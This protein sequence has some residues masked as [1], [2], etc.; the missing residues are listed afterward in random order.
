MPRVSLD[1]ETANAIIDYDYNDTISV[2]IDLFD[3]AGKSRRYEDIP[4]YTQFGWILKKTLIRP[5]EVLDLK[6]AILSND[7]YY[8][9]K[10]KESTETEKSNTGYYTNNSFEG[11]TIYYDMDTYY[12][13]IMCQNSA[14][15]GKGK[16]EIVNDIKDMFSKLGAEDKYLQNLNNAV[17]L[18]RI[19][20]KR[21]TRYR[22]EQHLYLIKFIVDIAPNYIVNKNYE[23]L[24]EKDEHP[25]IE[26]FDDIEYMKKFKSE[27]NKTAEF[28]IYDK[29]LETIDR[30]NKGLTTQ[31]ELDWYERTIRFEV[32]I[33]NGKLNSIRANL[34]KPKKEN[35]RKT[36]PQL[37]MEKDIDNY[38]D[39]NIADILFEEY[40]Q[41]VFFKSD[42]FKLDYAIRM[43]YKC[44]ERKATRRIMVKLLKLIH[45]K[46]YTKAREEFDKFDYYI[47]KFEENGINPLTFPTTWTDKEGNT[48]KTTYTSIP[49][50]IQPKSCVVDESYFIPSKWA[51]AMEQKKN[52]TL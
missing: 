50:F 26:N 4:H 17:V 44:K 45:E 31:E 32:R 2:L 47:K 39:G 38:R 35:K 33:K 23:K 40:A 49:N 15:R 6:R 27:S 16:L 12:F 48:H 3:F 20:Y 52:D 1:Y 30:F 9:E 10:P 28:V 25:E 24:D 46:G 18:S 21:D 36:K 51:K 29:Y 8:W 41:Q 14:I 11:Y 37:A 43:I 34:Y 22:N 13:S 7:F 42:F 19:D 5:S